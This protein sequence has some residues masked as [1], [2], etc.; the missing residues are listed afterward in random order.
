MAALLRSSAAG[1]AGCAA[2][3]ASG[4][5]LAA[6]IFFARSAPPPPV[7]AGQRQYSAS[8]H[9]VTPLS[10]AER[11][12]LFSELVIAR[13]DVAHVA[14]GGT[15]RSF[16]GTHWDNM[17][18]GTYASATC[19]LPL[20]RS[21]D[22]FECGC[23]WPSFSAP[24]DPEHVVESNDYSHDMIRVEV[25]EARTGAHLGHVFDDGPPPTYRRYCINSTMLC[26]VPEGE[27][28]PKQVIA[29]SAAD[30]AKKSD[31]KRVS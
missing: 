24:Y 16:T 11:A 1:A 21:A 22:K 15:E 23:G 10:L 17:A 3:V 30:D 9:D 20:F 29:G 26:F 13:P 7:V 14:A 19:G 27:P 25:C 8:G 4:G 28:L 6:V 18:S 2:L 12:R 31:D 5:A